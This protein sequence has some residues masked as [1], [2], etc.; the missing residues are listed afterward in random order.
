[1]TENK[2]PSVH[3][4]VPLAVK[5]LLWTALIIA[6]G[7]LVGLLLRGIRGPVWPCS[8]RMEANVGKCRSW[9]EGAQLS[10]QRLAVEM[11]RCPKANFFRVHWQS[12]TNGV[13]A[14]YATTY[15]RSF[16]Q[17]GYE[18]D[19]HSGCSKCWSNVSAATIQQVANRHG[20]FK[21]FGDQPGSTP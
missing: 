19:P 5:T 10:I 18:D 4:L 7:V 6:V 3:P 13:V 8:D 16:Q 2:W 12:P 20:Q 15:T 21:D 14:R 17:L 11:N 9:E 1:M